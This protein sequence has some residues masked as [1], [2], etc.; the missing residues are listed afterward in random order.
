[1][2]RSLGT[3]GTTIFSYMKPVV[4]RRGRQVVVLT[5]RF[6]SVTTSRH[7]GLAVA[8]ARADGLEIVWPKKD[9]SNGA[10]KDCC[11]VN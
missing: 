9:P 8:A 4:E 11:N 6:W 10:G 3:D 1:M 5:D 2:G 7:I